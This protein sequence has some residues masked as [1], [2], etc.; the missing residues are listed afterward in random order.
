[1]KKTITLMML[2]AMVSSANAD[3]VLNTKGNLYV[4]PGMFTTDGKAIVYSMN[5]NDNTVTI[6]TPD[7]LVDKSFTPVN[8]GF[9]QGY[10]TDVATV[11]PTGV[12]V[13]PEGQYWKNYS[14]YVIF[15]G[16]NSQEEMINILKEQSPSSTLVLF[17]DPMGNFACY[18][19][20][21]TSYKYENL[22]GKKYPTSWYALVDG[23]VCSIETYDRFYTIAY[24]EESVVWTRTQ[25][26]LYSNEDE[27]IID[28]LIQNEGI[29][30]DN[31][32][33]VSQSLFND[34]DKCEYIIRAYGALE[35]E[36]FSLS[37]VVNDDGTVTLTRS[38]HAVS[39]SIGYAVY[40]EDGA[41][42]GNIPSD[43]VEI[44]N[45][46]LYVKAY[47]SERGENLLYEITSNDG[48]IDL[49]EVVGAKDDCRF[50]A[51]RGIVIVDINAEQAGGEVIVST[52]DGKVMANK[53]VGVGQTQINDQPLP[54][55]IYVVSLLKDGRVVESEKYLVQ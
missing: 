1:M 2:F 27:G 52:T 53:K 26:D 29:K 22:F 48:F 18:Y 44:I 7:F 11:T 19:Y 3:L 16:T 38:G 10:V 33:Y 34:D 5:R 37:V 8:S 15:G 17:T 42:I 35:M 36:T 39:E 6:Y 4:C 12:N 31:G 21:S 41:R 24:N 50:D 9:Q 23:Q 45:G 43:R 54:T 28:P 47:D 51:T 32:L 30:F 14:I 46:R 20:E 49:V 25:E 13:T 40:N 55:G